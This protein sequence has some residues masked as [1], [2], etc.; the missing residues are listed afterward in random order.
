VLNADCAAERFPEARL[1]WRDCKACWDAETLLDAATY[2][3]NPAVDKAAIAI[4]TLI[5]E[6]IFLPHAS[7]FG[8]M[9]AR[10]ENLSGSGTRVG[11][12]DPMLEVWRSL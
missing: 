7:L 8:S 9:P 6:K 12:T 3:E 11:T 2:C 4:R 5:G 1:C 10:L